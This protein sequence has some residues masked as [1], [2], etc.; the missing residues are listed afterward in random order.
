MRTIVLCSL[1]AIGC[2]R[3]NDPPVQPTNKPSASTDEKEFVA[4]VKSHAQKPDNLTVIDFGEPQFNEYHPTDY[5]REFR[6]R[7]DIV[8]H[9]RKGEPVSLEAG[10]VHFRKGKL[11]S[12]DLYTCHKTWD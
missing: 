8:D 2:S 9:G 11:T 1:L 3:P 5:Y 7:C 4:F 10:R 6:I 12:V